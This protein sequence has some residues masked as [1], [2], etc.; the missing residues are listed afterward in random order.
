[1]VIFSQILFIA[2]FGCLKSNKLFFELGKI[3]WSWFKVLIP[4]LRENARCLDRHS[5][6]T[7]IV[8]L[9]KE[10]QRFSLFLV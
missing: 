9:S 4:R 1:M 7:L 6:K 3:S 10:I 5:F 8:V 2:L